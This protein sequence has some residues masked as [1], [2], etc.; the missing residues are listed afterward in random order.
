MDKSEM[1]NMDVFNDFSEGAQEDS[2][3]I[4]YLYYICGYLMDGK[5]SDEEN[6]QV[7]AAL[8][9]KLNQIEKIRNSYEEPAPVGAGNTR[10]IVLNILDT[11]EN[12]INEIY[13]YLDNGAS[14]DNIDNVDEFDSENMDCI[15]TA[16]SLF[17]IA[18]HMI[19]A[20]GDSVMQQRM[21]IAEILSRLHKGEIKEG[22]PVKD[23]ITSVSVLDND[24]KRY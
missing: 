14:I 6:S 7:N 5:L 16:I 8:E 22:E 19:D 13:N 23:E 4:N 18:E 12:G 24:Y 21:E 10:K 1:E 3:I 2:D 9:V 17:E 11:I 15:T 20:L